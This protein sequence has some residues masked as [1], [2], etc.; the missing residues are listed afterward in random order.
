M[1]G[2][3]K[4]G[5][6]EAFGVRFDRVTHI[7]ERPTVDTSKPGDFGADPLPDGT[8]LMVPSGDVVDYAE[9]CRRLKR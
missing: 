6:I 9:R 8:Y 7:I 1:S 5:T 4:P 2:A 3:R